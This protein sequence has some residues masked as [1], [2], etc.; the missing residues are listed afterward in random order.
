V[1]VYRVDV[2][3][4]HAELEPRFVRLLGP[5]LKTRGD[6]FSFPLRNLVTLIQLFA[7]ARAQPMSRLWRA[8]PA[9]SR[10]NPR[11]VARGI[12]GG[13]ISVSVNQTPSDRPRQAR[14]GFVDVPVEE[15]VAVATALHRLRSSLVGENQSVPQVD[16]ASAN[17]VN[18]RPR[19][20]THVRIIRG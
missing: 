15:T 5:E 13:R 6:G 16:P 4:W 19:P 20:A 10:F 7:V 17:P 18:H 9:G 11:A 12:A 14:V 3:P 1:T 2:R 8:H